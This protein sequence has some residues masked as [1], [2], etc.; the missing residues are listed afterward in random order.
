MIALTVACVFVGFVSYL[1]ARVYGAAFWDCE[2]WDRNTYSI[3][4]F[5]GLFATVSASCFGYA[6]LQWVGFLL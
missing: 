6:A 2:L 4:L 3:L 5:F 1:M